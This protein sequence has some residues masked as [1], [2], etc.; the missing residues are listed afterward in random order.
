M[1][2]QEVQVA[3][4][5]LMGLVAVLP[6]LTTLDQHDKRMQGKLELTLQLIRVLGNRGLASTDS[7]HLVQLLLTGE[8]LEVGHVEILCRIWA[9]SLTGA[10]CHD[11][12]LTCRG[13]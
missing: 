8:L 12:Q 13:T 3:E 10:S 2:Q 7:H 5:L 11:Y 6:Q 9:C 4:H 1:Q